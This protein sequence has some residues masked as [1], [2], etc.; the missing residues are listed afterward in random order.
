[1]KEACDS[2]VWISGTR[3]GAQDDGH[4]AGGKLLAANTHTEAQA[5]HVPVHS[6]DA[7]P[8]LRLLRCHH[9]VDQV[10]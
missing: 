2:S 7:A 10:L 5:Q 9:A 3:F 8:F 6:Q 1:M 4:G